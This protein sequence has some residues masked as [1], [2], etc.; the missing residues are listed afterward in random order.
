MNGTS[1][2]IVLIL[3]SFVGACVGA[4]IGV[5]L[6]NHKGSLRN[7]KNIVEGVLRDNSQDSKDLEDEEVDTT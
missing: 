6:G 1:H 2:D 5:F 4:Y 3:A 7:K